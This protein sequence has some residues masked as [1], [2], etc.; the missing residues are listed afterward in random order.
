VSDEEETRGQWVDDDLLE[1]FNDSSLGGVSNTT[2]CILQTGNQPA[3]MVLE[4][5]TVL[6]GHL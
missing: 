3:N 6:L 5:Q 1:E 2:V 4:K